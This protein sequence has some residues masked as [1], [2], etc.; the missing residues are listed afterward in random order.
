M[1]QQLI[2]KILEWVKA[3]AYGQSL[4]DGA[5][6]DIITYGEFARF[7]NSLPETNRYQIAREVLD[8]YASMLDGN[9]EHVEYDL[10]LPW[11]TQQ[12]D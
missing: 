12:E 9:I 11:L 5:R 4:E 2:D 8:E 1:E 10:F 3:N 7:L 6:W